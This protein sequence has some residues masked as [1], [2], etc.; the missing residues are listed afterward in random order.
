[1]AIEDFLREV[2]Q[3][4]LVDGGDDDGDSEQAG[5]ASVAAGLREDAFARVDED[6]GDVGGGGAGGHVARV[7]LVTGSVGD[8]EF[9]LRGREVA[10]GDVDGNA[11]LAF[12]AKAVGELGEVDGGVAGDGANVV[13]VD[14]VRVVKQAADERGFA[15][16]DAA[17]GGEAEQSPWRVRLRG[18]A[19]WE[20][21]DRT[22]V[23]L[24]NAARTALQIPS[25]AKAPLISLAF[26]ARLKPSSFKT[27]VV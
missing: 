11:L 8:D 12:G 27:P 1:M 14:V 7:L 5:N 6:D 4:H 24:L 26:T 22:R 21:A 20:D 13:V 15:I 16:V 9:A 23:H 17:G 25:G 3:I 19:R 2:D 18:A 10:V